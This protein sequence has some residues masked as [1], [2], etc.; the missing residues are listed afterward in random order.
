MSGSRAGRSAEVAAPAGAAPEPRL[1]TVTFDGSLLGAAPVPH[2]VGGSPGGVRRATP[3]SSPRR[4][5][6]APGSTGSSGRRKPAAP[7]EP[8]G[9]VLLD[10]GESEA[11][12]IGTL[13]THYVRNGTAESFA[14]R[15]KA[16][17][18][19][20]YAGAH[21]GPPPRSNAASGAV[22]LQAQEQAL[23]EEREEELVD[24]QERRFAQLEDAVAAREA[25]RE[26][27]LVHRL[28][29]SAAD[30]IAEHRRRQEAAARQR[31]LAAQHAQHMP[32]LKQA[33]SAAQP[34]SGAAALQKLAARPVFPASP[35]LAAAVP[36]ASAGLSSLPAISTLH[37][38]LEAGTVLAPGSDALRSG[39]PAL[40]GGR[41][42][43]LDKQRSAAAA[44]VQDVYGQI[45]AVKTAGDT[46]L[47]PLDA[48]RA[49]ADPSSA[50][51]EK[52]LAADKAA[53]AVAA[54]HRV[55]EE[56]DA[57]DADALAAAYEARQEAAGGSPEAALPASGCLG[58]TSWRDTAARGS[59]EGPVQQGSEEPQ[60]L[61][62][63]EQP[64]SSAH[65]AEAGPTEP[66]MAVPSAAGLLQE[67]T[68]AQAVHGTA[69][70]GVAACMQQPA[71]AGA[72]G[73]AVQDELAA[74]AAPT[75]KELSA[76]SGGS[77][78]CSAGC[79]L[80]IEAGSNEPGE[81]TAAQNQHAEQGQVEPL[82]ETFVSAPATQQ[83]QAQEQ[84]EM[85]S[86]AEPCAA[87]QH[88]G[89]EQPLCAASEEPAG[90]E[91]GLAGATAVRAASAVEASDA[92]HATM[93]AM[94]GSHAAA[95]ADAAWV[96]SAQAA[97]TTAEFAP[98]EACVAGGKAAKADIVPIDGLEAVAALE[99][100]AM[101]GLN[102][103]V[104]AALLQEP[105]YRL[106]ACMEQEQQLQ[107]A[108]PVQE[109]SPSVVAVL[110]CD[111]DPEGSPALPL[112]EPAQLQEPLPPSAS[113]DT[114]TAAGGSAALD[115]ETVGSGLASPA[116][117]A[118]RSGL[119]PADSAEAVRPTGRASADLLFGGGGGG[120]EVPAEGGSS[121]P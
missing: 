25:K 53:V 112:E 57:G 15:F 7:R 68:F 56:E 62:R 71:E 47:S 118:E 31:L 117:A 26:A 72:P 120:G 70:P 10:K 111:H 115:G 54:Q 22:R 21:G 11:A 81:A 38:G 85:P 86:D 69:S 37:A 40:G 106:P 95:A 108:R 1:A 19:K 41:A 65:A 3:G 94:V 121:S 45:Q 110:Q 23:W 58:R 49:A 52:V 55:W 30:K 51:A 87:G 2:A 4:T 24:A 78:S 92:E 90:A 39:A 73:E 77:R 43:W 109:A 91:P 114:T 33:V 27:Y 83:L 14:P 113:A 116:V 28:E 8:P 103:A 13:R 89:E 82:V 100:A 88:L 16:A 119:A 34:A 36:H 101:A 35:A 107:H 61:E 99:A 18:H 97:D 64:H 98:A 93:Q 74:A 59:E 50:A 75:A 17:P 46:L 44:A 20:A 6:S 29:A 5:P 84:D 104:A 42:T 67:L 9:A 12:F 80:H 32:A 105:G 76:G 60:D 66:A 102:A 48:A 79:E 96:G 63:L